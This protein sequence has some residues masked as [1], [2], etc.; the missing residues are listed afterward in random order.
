MAARD[1][2]AQAWLAGADFKADL[3]VGLYGDAVYEQPD[4]GGW[5]TARAAAGADYSFGDFIVAAEYYYNGGG[6][7]ADL[8]Y[9]DVHNVYASLTWTASELF[10][11][12]LSTV[13]GFQGGAG[14]GTLL[15][16]ISAAQNADVTA[17]LEAAHGT[18]GYGLGYGLVGADWNAQAGAGLEVKF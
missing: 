12:T 6:A 8:L 16:R 4:N 2:A 7:A 14:T 11:L 18:A 9:P 5:G 3:I 1:G 15:A 10:T 13:V 17:Y